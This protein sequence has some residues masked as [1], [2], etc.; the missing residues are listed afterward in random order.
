VVIGKAAFANIQQ[1]SVI[2][3]SH[4][5]TGVCSTTPTV[6]QQQLQTGIS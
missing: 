2:A 6:G 5:V 3:E 4:A 1:L